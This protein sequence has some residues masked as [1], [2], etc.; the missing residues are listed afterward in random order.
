MPDPILKKYQQ[1]PVYGISLCLGE[2][3]LSINAGVPIKDLATK[4]TKMI[5]IDSW[6]NDNR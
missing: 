3:C 2:E 5:F 4:L 1:F 6:I